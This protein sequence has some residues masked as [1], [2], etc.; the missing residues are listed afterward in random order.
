MLLWARS[1]RARGADALMIRERGLPGG[2]LAALML[3]LYPALQFIEIPIL[4]AASELPAG[5]RADGIHHSADEQTP[6]PTDRAL[7]YGRSCHSKKEVLAA[8]ADGYDYVFYSPIFPTRSHPRAEPV[9]LASLQEICTQVQ[10]PVF[11]LG[12]I[13]ETTEDECLAAGARGVASIRR[14]MY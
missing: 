11:A 2:E 1:A 12:G 6:L 9:G 10:I 13:T 3:E 14:F 8:M 4:L 7:L 5:I